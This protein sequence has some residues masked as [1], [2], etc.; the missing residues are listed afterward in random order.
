MWSRLG[1][2]LQ[3]AD[4]RPPHRNLIPMKVQAAGGAYDI[5]TVFFGARRKRVP[6]P[7]RS[8]IARKVGV[9]KCQPAVEV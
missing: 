7:P 2:R 6:H 8:F 1:S 3:L 5:R 4:K 9:Y